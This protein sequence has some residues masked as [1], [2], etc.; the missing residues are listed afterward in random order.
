MLERG[1]K[2]IALGDSSHFLDCKDHD[3][4][5]RNWI[6]SKEGLDTFLDTRLHMDCVSANVEDHG[7]VPGAILESV[8]V[9]YLR[10]KVAT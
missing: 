3:A 4:M 5:S 1:L 9:T 7:E 2:G 8:V 10:K 6:P